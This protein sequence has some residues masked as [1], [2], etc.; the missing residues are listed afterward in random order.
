MSPADVLIAAVGGAGNVLEVEGC[1]GRLRFEVRDQGLVDD[2]AMRDVG[3]HAV[4]RSGPVVQIV[5]GPIA[6][7]LADEV[8]YAVASE[9]L[10]AGPGWRPR[11]G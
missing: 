10:A 6:A 3:A 7:A 9:N 11:L 2:A 8:A 4:V 5:V 1:V